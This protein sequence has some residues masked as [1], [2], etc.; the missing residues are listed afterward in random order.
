MEAA[1]AAE[2]A[3]TLSAEEAAQM[4]AFAEVLDDQKQAQGQA[5]RADGG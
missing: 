5:Q 4:A 3:A 2:A 1:M